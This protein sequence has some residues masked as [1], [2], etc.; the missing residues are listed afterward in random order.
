AKGVTSGYQPVGGV[1]VGRSVLDVLEADGDHV[2]RH[3]FTYSGHPAACTAASANIAVLREE[4]LLARAEPLGARLAAGLAPLVA[5]GLAGELRGA[6]AV[7]GLGMVDG[8]SA[9][10][11]RD[12]MLARGVIPRPIADHSVAFC[13]PLVTTDAQ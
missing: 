1:L 12:A 5:E 3:G 11:V 4:D 8:V 7:W 2:L 9:L 10:A 13:P 6:G